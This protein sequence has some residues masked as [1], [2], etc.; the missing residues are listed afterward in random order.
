FLQLESFFD[1]NHMKD[2]K[3]SENPLPYFTELKEKYPHGFLNVPI[4]G[5]GTVNT[6]F[7]AM[8]GLNLDDFGPGEY[9]F[10]TA[11]ADRTCESICFNLKEYGYSCHAVHNNTAT[12]YGR[13]KVFSN[14]GYD[15]FTT[16]ENINLPVEDKTKMGW[17]KDKYLTNYIMKA[18]KSTKKQDYIYTIS[19]QGHGSYPSDPDNYDITIEGINDS[20]RMYSFEYYVKQIN[21]MDQFLVDL[22]NNLSKYDEKTIL[23]MYGDH[24]PSL[25]ISE[26]ELDNGDVYQTEY[27]IWSNYDFGYEDEDIECYE[28]QAKILG[29]LNMTAGYINNYSQK[30]RHDDDR[31]AYLEGLKNIGYDMLYG[32]HLLYNGE[33][34]Y[35]ATKL[36]FGQNKVSS[37]SISQ[38]SKNDNTIFIYGK[39]FTNYSKVYVN[40]EKINT[41]FVDSSVLTINYDDLKDGDVF[42]VHQQVSEKNIL[43]VTNKVVYYS[44][45]LDDDLVEGLG[46]FGEE[47]YTTKHK[48]KLQK[49]K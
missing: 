8:T 32:E 45:D 29:Q 30:H 3:Y 6:E 18:L 5:A 15:T 4:V 26:D 24:L 46:Y 28:L 37:S 42:E 10:K 11:V 7:E 14:L 2:L 1:V 17:A 25:G 33:N 47:E 19:V 13:N 44:E 23:V 49:D 20:S 22:T 34:P 27:V 48:N 40:G 36:Q 35:V 9:P 41:K 12:F 43:N 38:T 21:E 39:N 31:E 16:I